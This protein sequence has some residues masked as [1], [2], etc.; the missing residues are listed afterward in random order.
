MSY[1]GYFMSHSAWTAIAKYNR[2]GDLTEIFLKALDARIQDQVPR[3]FGSSW[4]LSARLAGGL[5]FTV[6]SHGGQRG[7]KFSGLFL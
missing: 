7:I 6:F 3:Q 1:S 4:G 2:W 5:L